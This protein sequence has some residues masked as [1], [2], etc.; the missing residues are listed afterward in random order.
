MWQSE[1]TPAN[2]ANQLH[3]LASVAGSCLLVKLCLSTV[4]PCLGDYDVTTIHRAK[5]LTRNLGRIDHSSR[6]L[7]KASELARGSPRGPDQSVLQVPQLAPVL[8]PGA[9]LH[10]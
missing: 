10:P 3:H 4:R 2:A 7:E 5:D 9:P 1:Q 8:Q 6:T